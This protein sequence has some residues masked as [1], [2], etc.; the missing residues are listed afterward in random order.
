MS[1]TFS[2]LSTDIDVCIQTDTP[3]P[4]SMRGVNP[5]S[6]VSVLYKHVPDLI[7]DQQLQEFEH[8]EVKSK[9]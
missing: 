5:E 2:H 1:E 7:G 8:V 9:K 4:L 6:Y 3:P